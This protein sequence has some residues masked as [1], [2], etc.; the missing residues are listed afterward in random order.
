VDVLVVDRRAGVAPLGSALVSGAW[1]RELAQ[2]LVAGDE[3]ALELAY[4]QYGA[5]VYGIARRVSGDASVA[6]DVAQDVFV[7]LWERPDRFDP[8]RGS[9][10]TF[11][12]VLARRRAIDVIRR[13]EASNRREE[14][15]GAQRPTSPPNVEE[16]ATAMVVGEKLRDAVAKLPADQQRAIELAYYRGLT[17]CEVAAEL[18]I[19]E[20]TAKSRLRTALA[21]L[22]QAL[23]G[24]GEV[25]WA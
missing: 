9:L 10:R 4:D 3:Q 17:Y 23:R 8:E 22:A 25:Q 24:E 20:G 5:I 1:D 6:S 21:R 19:P 14:R 11:L 15:V 2:R 18:G 13:R 12:A 16:A 7:Q